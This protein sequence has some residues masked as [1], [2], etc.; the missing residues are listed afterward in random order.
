M[1]YIYILIFCVLLILSTQKKKP[2]ATTIIFAM[3]IIVIAANTN[4]PDFYIYERW[5]ETNNYATNDL[6]YH[7]VS[8][9]L[10]NIGVP[11][12]L[13]RLIY[14]VT[15]LLLIHSTLKRVYGDSVYFY[16]LYLL[17]PFMMD[18]VQ[19]RNFIAMSIFISA[20]PFIISKN[21]LGWL[22][23]LLIMLLASGFQILFLLFLPLA[24]VMKIKQYKLLRYALIASAIVLTT[25][26][27]AFTSSLDGLIGWLTD[28]F[29]EYDVRISTYMSF[30]FGFVLQLVFVFLNYFVLLVSRHI[31][32]TNVRS[33][34]LAVENISRAE[35]QIKFIELL[36]WINVFVF[37][38][39]PFIVVNSGFSRIFRNIMPLNYMACL[40]TANF[41]NNVN[42]KINYN[43]MCYYLALAGYALFSFSLRIYSDSYDTILRP[44]FEQNLLFGL[45]S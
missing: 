3:L 28:N 31:V 5:Y 44:L 12:G 15:G 17:Y 18:V 29:S 13:F 2:F 9:G 37:L 6:I 14:S 20:V 11:Y 41:I 26:S 30:N 21:K 19:A 1:F 8:A 24:F 40:C 10:N 4:N 16:L 32:R 27:L 23:Y 39:S 35:I 43:K 34:Q 42:Y 36:Y 33:G 22:K 25:M 7:I 45:F 38:Y